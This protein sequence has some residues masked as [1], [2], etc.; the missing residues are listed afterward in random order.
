MHTYTTYFTVITVINDNFIMKL[1]I[2][3]FIV[4]KKLKKKKKKSKIFKN[5]FFFQKIKK[6]IIIEKEVY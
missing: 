4:F 2:L 3:L 5:I 6:L 1:R